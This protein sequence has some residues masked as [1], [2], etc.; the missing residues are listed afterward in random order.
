V[1]GAPGLCADGVGNGRGDEAVEVE[2]EEDG[3][4]AADEQLDQEHPRALSVQATGGEAAQ[5]YQLKPSRGSR[6]SATIEAMAA[7]RGGDAS[8]L[9]GEGA[10]RL[11]WGRDGK[12]RQHSR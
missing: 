1:E 11:H 5:R 7:A 9:G 6:G 10:R 12:V 4:D 8:W 3:Q 2:E